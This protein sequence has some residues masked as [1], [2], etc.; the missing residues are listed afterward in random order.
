MITVNSGAEFVELGHVDDTEEPKEAQVARV[1]PHSEFM[2]F[3]VCACL[4]CN[5]Q[6]FW[7]TVRSWGGYGFWTEWN[8]YAY[9]LTL[10][11]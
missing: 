2:M 3:Y 1:D 10:P 7:Q 5:L 11:E 8:G 6:F 9:V 4:S